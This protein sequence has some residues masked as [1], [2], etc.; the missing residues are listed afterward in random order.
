MREAWSPESPYLVFDGG[1]YGAGHQHEDKLHFLLH[2]HGR[3][4]ITDPGIYSYRRDP[5][6]RYF[7]S[8][9]A[10]N[11]IIVDGKEQYRYHLRKA[12][13]EGPDPD[14][15]WETNDLFAFVAGIYNDGFT[16][17]G[18]QS[19]N[20]DT[21]STE[22]D[23]IHQRSIFHPWDGFYLVSDRVT[24][25]QQDKQR[26]L[27]QIFQLAPIVENKEESLVRPVN[28]VLD[29]KTGLART[30]ETGYANLMLLP[31][32]PDLPEETKVYLGQTEPDVR[33]WVTLYGRN[34]AHDLVYKYKSKLPVKMNTLIFTAPEGEELSPQISTSQADTGK[35]ISIIIEDRGYIDYLLIS[36]E[37]PQKMRNGKFE[38]QGE[39]LWLRTD[40]AGQAIAAGAINGTEISWGGQVLAGADNP[41]Y[42]TWIKPY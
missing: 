17:I 36:D 20:R 31:V 7:R 39:I 24:D 23:I 21:A 16:E 11:S 32:G 13:P 37:G 29:E 3:S 41:G 18:P 25:A 2:A 42:L 12:R 28:L 19:R 27:E 35:G 9:R 6:E 15:R 4:M 1:F 26:S 8:A 22:M 5:Y 30:E 14:A 33:G 34:P 38:G 40:S 10:H